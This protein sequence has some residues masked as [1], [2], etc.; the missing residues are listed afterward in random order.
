MSLPADSS[1]EKMI[2]LPFT[3]TGFLKP[4]PAGVVAEKG[5]EYISARETVGSGEERGFSEERAEEIM[6]LY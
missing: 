2:S 5:S 1:C 3:W 6:F 4:T